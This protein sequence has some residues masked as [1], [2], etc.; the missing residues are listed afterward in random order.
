MLLLLLVEVGN[1]EWS[2]TTTTTNSARGKPYHP[3][4]SW[5]RGRERVRWS[6]M[7]LLLLLLLL[8]LRCHGPCRMAILLL[9]L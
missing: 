6:R 2:T 5:C 7:L 1:V 3:R 8:L 9:L 4:R